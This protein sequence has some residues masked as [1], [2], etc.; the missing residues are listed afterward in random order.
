M[1]S[2]FLTLLCVAADNQALAG[3]LGVVQSIVAGIE[4][5]ATVAPVAVQGFGALCNICLNCNSVTE[6]ADLQEH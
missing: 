5:H 6:Y 4:C 2:V 1:H 3:K